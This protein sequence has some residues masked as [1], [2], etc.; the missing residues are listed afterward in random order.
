MAGGRGDGKRRRDATTGHGEGTSDE[1]QGTCRD[2]DTLSDEIYEGEGGAV[3]ADAEHR[4]VG[5]LGRKL[6]AEHALDVVLDRQGEQRDAAPRVHPAASPCH[7]VPCP[8][9]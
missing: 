9:W 5:A 2:D 8:C 7:T 1:R 6:H 3:A 4:G